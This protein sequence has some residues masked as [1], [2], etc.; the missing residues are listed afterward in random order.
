MFRSRVAVVLLMSL[1]PA[2]SSP[3]QK[4]AGTA[5]AASASA[6]VVAPAPSP[7]PKPAPPRP[8]AGVE[9]QFTKFM[10]D[11]DAFSA[12]IVE[13]AKTSFEAALDVFVARR[14]ALKKEFDALKDLPSN[15]VKEETF[16]AFTDNVTHGLNEVCAFGMG[17]SETARQFKRLCTEYRKLL[18]VDQLE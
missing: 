1:G 3:D 17:G 13:A 18:E 7:A 15:A 14:D 2:C 6:T 10:A 12:A 16:T 8:T 11:N 5:P 4:S 9:G